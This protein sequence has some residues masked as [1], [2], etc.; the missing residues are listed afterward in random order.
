MNTV[1][2]D[3]DVV[4]QREKGAVEQP[5]LPEYDDQHG[6]AEIGAVGEHR[7]ELEHARILDP[8]VDQ[9]RQQRKRH[10]EHRRHKR[11]VQTGAQPFLGIGDLQRGQDQK[12]LRD[13]DQQ[14]GEQ[15]GRV[16]GKDLEQPRRDP[17]EHHAE[18]RQDLGG[19]Q[20]D[21][22]AHTDKP[23]FLP[24]RR[25]ACAAKP[26]RNGAILPFCRGVVNRAQINLKQI[27]K[28]VLFC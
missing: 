2:A 26:L 11:D 16:L 24:K 19:D 8:S 22:G 14:R 17:D 3:V 10:M 9:P 1:N 6:V 13:V 12:R 18:Q 21:V 15:L 28:K 20:R 7:P 5:L 23:S 25:Y 27:S 4:E